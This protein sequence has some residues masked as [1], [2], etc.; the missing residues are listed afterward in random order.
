MRRT[1]YIV[2]LLTSLAHLPFDRPPERDS[3]HVHRPSIC[4][5][6]CKH[7]TVSHINLTRR[8]F[9]NG[10]YVPTFLFVTV[11]DA[12]KRSPEF[13]SGNAGRRKRQK[14]LPEVARGE[15]LI[16]CNADVLIFA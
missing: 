3:L 6:S 11:P 1:D 9:D 14:R 7:T 2:E 4:I 16:Y 5:S 13:H 10:F 15:Y 8:L 12:R